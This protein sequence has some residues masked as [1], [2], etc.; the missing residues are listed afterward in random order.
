MSTECAVVY[1]AQTAQA[2]SAGTKC[3]H[4]IVFLTQKW[5]NTT[6]IVMLIAITVSE[7]LESIAFMANI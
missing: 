4:C 2:F 7:R 3:R 6:A 1:Y 5:N